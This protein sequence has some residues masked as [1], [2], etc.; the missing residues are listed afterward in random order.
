VR[1]RTLARERRDGDLHD[2]VAGVGLDVDRIEDR[3]EAR[4]APPST[5]TAGVIVRAVS[6]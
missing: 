6:S 1:G 4:A 5:L 3:R 2:D